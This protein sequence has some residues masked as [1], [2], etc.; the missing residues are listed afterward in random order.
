MQSMHSVFR[1]ETEVWK[2][3][4]LFH[5]AAHKTAWEPLVSKSL[6]REGQAMGCPLLSCDWRNSNAATAYL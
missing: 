1:F 5:E 4:L 6:S 2:H 3:K